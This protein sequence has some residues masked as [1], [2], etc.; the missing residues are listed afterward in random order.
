MALGRG[1]SASG[2]TASMNHDAALFAKTMSQHR[3][4][5]MPG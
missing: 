2:P 3:S 5:A 1:K 4:T